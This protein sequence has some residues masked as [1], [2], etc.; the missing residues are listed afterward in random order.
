MVQLSYLV[1]AE[2]LAVIFDKNSKATF[3]P[4]V[5]FHWSLS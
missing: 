1:I 3:T 2:D 4:V 5:Y